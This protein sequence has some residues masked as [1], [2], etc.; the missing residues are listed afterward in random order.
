VSGSVGG[1]S[2]RV[3]VAGIGIIDRSACCVT[4]ITLPI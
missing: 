2:R 1:H 4:V 3:H